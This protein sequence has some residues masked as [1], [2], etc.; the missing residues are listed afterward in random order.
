MEK[1]FRH[2]RRGQLM[3]MLAPR[4]VLSKIILIPNVLAGIAT[5]A[6]GLEA[7]SMSR[8]RR[9]IVAD[10]YRNTTDNLTRGRC[11]MN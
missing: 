7:E 10:S 3:P 1:V 9:G 2:R 5:G 11:Q 6:F 8:G 4:F